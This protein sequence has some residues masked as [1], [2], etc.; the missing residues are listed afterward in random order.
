MQ[1]GEIRDSTQDR[2]R[3]AFILLLLGA[4]GIAF[5]PIFVRLSELGPM[6]TA[7]WRCALAVPALWLWLMRLSVMERVPQTSTR[8]S[9]MA[10]TPCP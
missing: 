8:S 9:H 1:G 10:K 3:L 2:A 5:A 7:F 6:T 4:A